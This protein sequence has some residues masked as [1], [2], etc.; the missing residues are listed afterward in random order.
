[1]WRGAAV[2]W[3]RFGNAP[4]NLIRRTSVECAFHAECWRGIITAASNTN[5]M[6][7]V[8]WKPRMLCWHFHCHRGK[9]E[10]TGFCLLVLW[11]AAVIASTWCQCWIA[12]R[13]SEPVEQFGIKRSTKLLGKL[14][15][16]KISAKKSTRAHQLSQRKTKDQNQIRKDKESSRA[17]KKAEKSCEISL[18]SRA[19]RI[20]IN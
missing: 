3:W 15:N 4:D 18:C 7:C 6:P 19:M 1:M 5:I 16:L 9:T 8:C 11:S 2:C 10:W 12:E 20:F 13:A 14:Q 17:G